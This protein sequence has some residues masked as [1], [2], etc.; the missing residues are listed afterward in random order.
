MSDASELFEA[1]E[2]LSGVLQNVHPLFVLVRQHGFQFSPGKEQ[3]D[4]NYLETL[5]YS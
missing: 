1:F 4:L 2:R 5:G 3:K